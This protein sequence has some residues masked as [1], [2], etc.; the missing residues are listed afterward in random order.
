MSVRNRVRKS[1]RKR[2][3]DR[4]VGKRAHLWVHKLGSIRKFPGPQ[5]SLVPVQLY[6]FT[7]HP[8][9][10]RAVYRK[11]KRRF[12]KAHRRLPPPNKRYIPAFSTRK[13]YDNIQPKVKPRETDAQVSARLRGE[14]HVD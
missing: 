14:G 11:M 7:L 5:G 4:T 12:F 3:L 6:H 9:C 1:L 2:A 10:T 8:Q 13:G